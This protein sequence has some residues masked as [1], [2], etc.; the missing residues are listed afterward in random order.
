MTSTSTKIIS[1]KRPY[2]PKSKQRILPPSSQK[3]SKQSMITKSNKGICFD[4]K[5]NELEISQINDSDSNGYL[6]R[7]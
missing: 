1:N 5:L 4:I 3:N 6:N 2:V 7:I